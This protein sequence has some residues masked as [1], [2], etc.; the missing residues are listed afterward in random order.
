MITSVEIE[1][2][3]GIAHGKLE[4]LT[5]LTVLVGP[6]GSGKSTILDALLLTASID[7]QKATNLVLNRRFG[8]H[9]QQ[10][11]LL[12]K[13]Q[14]C[15]IEIKL[16][17]S[18][19][20]RWLSIQLD[21][22]GGY[23]KFKYSDSDEKTDLSKF[24]AL[25]IDNKSQSYQRKLYEIYSDVARN[26]GKEYM[27]NLLR[28]VI[29]GFSNVEIL[30]ETNKSTSQHAT[31]LNIV[32]SGTAGSVPVSLAGDGIHALIRMALEIQLS[33]GLALIEE[34]EAHQHPAT[35]RQIAR[36]V[37]ASVRLGN[38]VI[39]TT[40]SMEL[41]DQLLENATEPTDLEKLSV[42]WM[43]LDSGELKT[44]RIPGED[45]IFERETLGKDLR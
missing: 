31:V 5:P 9:D 33:N 30:T 1:N 20:V 23:L 35:I 10:K 18:E 28:E 26:G 2:L 32:F 24:S 34:P 16:D 37:F 38:Q 13:S 11:W 19:S 45:V 29:P 44:I 41:I 25:L 27:N 17:G 36:A 15:K 43:K 6:N 42:F 3:R 14:D 39:L 22:E 12:R 21:S 4:G 7:T 8:D 40:H